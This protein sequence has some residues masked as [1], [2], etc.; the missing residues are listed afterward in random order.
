MPITYEGQPDGKGLSIGIVVARFNEFVTR[1]LLD[2]AVRALK[3]Q[4]VGDSDIHIAWVP[5]A[6]ELGFGALEL[7]KSQ[8]LDAV[9]ALGAVIRGDTSHYDYVCDASAHQIRDVSILTERPVMF[10]VLTTENPE[11]ALS[12]AGDGVDNKGYESA[13]GALEMAQLSRAIEDQ[14]TEEQA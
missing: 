2:G 1:K 13:L 7:L 14:S 10:G 6:F 5:G 12:R 3:D 11:Q 4:G 9:I 8:P